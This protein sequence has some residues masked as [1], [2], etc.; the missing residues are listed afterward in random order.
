MRRTTATAFAAGENETT[1]LPGDVNGD[2][3]VDVSDGKSIQFFV[4]DGVVQEIDYYYDV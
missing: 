1:V 4:E 3:T 2:G